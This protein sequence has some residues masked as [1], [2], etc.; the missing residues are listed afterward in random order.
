M[1]ASDEWLQHRSTQLLKPEVL[2]QSALLIAPAS[3]QQPEND[4]DQSS[5][6]NLWTMAL[7][8]DEKFKEIIKAIEQGNRRFPPDL[9]LQVTIDECSLDDKGRPRF[10]EQLWVLNY[11]PL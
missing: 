1:D 10:R 11:E 9:K 5:I 4:D 3:S 2:P 6:E 8:K 7:D